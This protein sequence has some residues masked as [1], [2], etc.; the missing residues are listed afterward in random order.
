M[1]NF[2]L[3]FEAPVSEIE[4]IGDW[5][6]S[7]KHRYDAPSIKLLSDDSYLRKLKSVLAKNIGVDFNLFFVKTSKASKHSEF[8]IVSET[9]LDEMISDV[10]ISKIIEASHTDAITVIFTNNIGIDKVPLTPWMI[11]HRIG[12]VLQR[13]QFKSVEIKNEWNFMLKNMIQTLNSCFGF[14]FKNQSDF[15]NINNDKTTKKKLLKLLNGL[16]TFR[17]ARRNEIDR[18]LEF[19]Y[20]CFAQ[21][22]VHGSLEFNPLDDAPCTYELQTAIES[23]IDSILNE[24]KG[25]MFLM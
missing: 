7:K 20:E 23:G 1:M 19:I 5:S 24:A 22:I 14:N 21:Y 6:S 13:A 15:Y 2:K 10:D 25:Y 9:Q 3:F 4:T 17:S 8:G 16:G 11:S 18:P 12:H